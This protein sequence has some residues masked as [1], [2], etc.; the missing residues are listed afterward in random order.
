MCKFETP[1][2]K[3]PTTH[4]QALAVNKLIQMK[5]HITI[6]ENYFIVAL[7]SSLLFFTGSVLKAQQSNKVLFL[8]NS[9]TGA[10]NLPQIISN[11]AL[12]V[13]DTLIYDSNT[14]GGYQLIDHSQTL[15]SQNKIATG[16]WDYIVLQGQSQ[17]PIMHYS[18]FTNGFSALVQLI[19]PTNPCTTIM[20]YMTWGRKNGDANN[21]L[22][23]PRMCT[24]EGMDTTLRDIYLDK[25]EAV[26]GEVSP[27]SV[28]WRYIRQNYPSIN[29]Y[30]S[31]ESHPSTAG[32]Y[33]A[34]CCFYAS[35]FKKD[36][37][38]V[39]FNF[40]LNAAD[41]AAIRSAAKTIVYDHLNLWDYKKL[42]HADIR[43]TAGAGVN[44][45]IFRSI[46]THRVVQN[47]LWDFGDGDTSTSH[48]P[49]HSYLA[50]GNYTVR[51]TVTNCDLQGSYTSFK[52]T[53]IQFCSHTPT[54]TTSHP[55]L[56]YNDTLWTQPA[57]T[58]QWLLNGSYIPETN[59]Y[60]VINGVVSGFSVVSTLNGCSELSE[61]YSET[62]ESSSYY[63]NI[64]LTMISI[65][66]PCQGDTVPFA[67][68][69]SNG[70]SG[71]EVIRWYKNDTL[72]SNMS[73]EDTLLITEPGK[74]VC[75][76][77]DPNANCQYD[78]AVFWTEY[79]CGTGIGLEDT[80]P[81]KQNLFWSVFP[82]PST[83]TISIKFTEKGIQEQIQI[84]NAVGQL[85]IESKASELTLINI[86]ELQVGVYFIRLKNN[87]QP[88]LR[89]MKQ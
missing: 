24:Y 34:A 81:Y 16:D 28:V 75:K 65:L 27:V 76:V 67:V 13:G 10:N 85:V 11:I 82:N 80:Y 57:D 89:F 6:R 7:L 20:P 15:T 48:A 63:S 39:T 84:H 53:V 66:N 54:I 68:S 42:P 22:S 86:S 62:P 55:W 2:F 77:I 74:Y 49:T 1:L 33:A 78:T 3:S 32:S 25:T 40:G 46:P 19:R 5:N 17:E 64:Y 45:I 50:D 69:Q 12:S 73:N 61:V 31:D 72:L 56:C 30:Q 8:G 14:P 36:P 44:E 4:S 47:Y 18:D 23:F 88:A 38:L 29:L 83:E 51:L 26:N 52:D 87:K 35:I 58:Y 37:T 9:Y 60:L 79:D 41:A 70:L 21:C 59:Q 71:L 43:Y